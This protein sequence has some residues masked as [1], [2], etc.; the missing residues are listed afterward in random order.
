MLPIVGF[1]GLVGLVVLTVWPRREGPVSRPE[2][3]RRVLYHIARRSIC[4][5]SEGEA[6]V[7][8]GIAN[9][10]TEPLLAPLSRRPCI[11]YH[12]RIQTFDG[13]VI[14]D[15]ARCA[16]F[17]LADDTGAVGVRGEGLELAVTDAPVFVA[18]PPLPPQLAPWVPPAIR[19][20]P[21]HI[22]EGLLLPGLEVAVCG[23]LQTAIVAGTMYR[24]RE[25]RYEL[26]SSPTFPL[27]AS[28][29]A[30]LVEPP[31]RPIRPEELRR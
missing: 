27:V 26:T 28:P 13:R 9:A 31:P 30:D 20:L 12:V 14:V 7:V 15:Q 23:V 11:G 24:D 21:L 3:V 29:D 5:L 18:Y 19:H 22:T 4:E 17:A 10:I 8:R 1:L 2:A 25:I 6:A 16:P